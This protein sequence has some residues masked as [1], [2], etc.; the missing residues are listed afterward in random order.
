[1]KRLT[2]CCLSLT[3]ALTL[4]LSSCSIPGAN[5]GNLPKL[6]PNDPVSLEIWHY[7]NGPQKSAFDA[8]VNEFN[9]TVGMERGIIVEAFSQGNVTE[10]ANKVLDAAAKKVGAEEVPDIFAAYADTAYEVD[11]LGLLADL[12]PYLSETDLAGYRQ[13]F[14]TEGDLSG[15][16]SLKIFPIAKSIEL[17]SI[18]ETDWLKFADATGV[19]LEQ[20]ATI[21]GV[22]SIAQAYYEWTDSLT[23]EPN[24]GKAF[25][26]RDAMANYFVI[27]CR[28]QGVEIFQ[29]QNGEVTVQASKETLRRLWDNYYIPF[30]NGWFSAN[31]R[32]RSDAAHMGDIIALVGASS[33]AAYFPE[34]VAISDF[35]SYPIGCLVFPAPILEGGEPFAVQQGAGMAVTSS[36][37]ATE[38]AAS[39]FLTWFTETERNAAFA[40]GSGYLPVRNDAL[41]LSL[42]TAAIAQEEDAAKADRMEKTFAAA[43]EQLE[44]CTLYTTRAF[45]GGNAARGVLESSMSDWAAH[46]RQVV[47]DLIAGGLSQ[48]EAVAQYDTDEHF[49]LWYSQLTETLATVVQ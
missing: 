47:L 6:N 15:D 13:E 43:L 48:E 27:G 33:G 9:E 49:D 46:D 4:G 32:F 16:G 37:P 21:E 44:T 11:K 2:A 38:Y 29:V 25:F 5:A 20:L 36:E 19:S 8:M 39:I 31:G 34:E 12:S 18:N 28:Q 10:L 30:I 24:D 1:M 23:P 7:Y 42:L 17:L 22:T 41:D 45:E 40:A 3:M 26:G 35:E 14:I